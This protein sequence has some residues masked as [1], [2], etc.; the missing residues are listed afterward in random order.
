[1]TGMDAGWYRDPAPANPASPATL[2][3][4][5]GKTWTP[6]TKVAS[7]RVRREWQEEATV[8]RLAQARMAATAAPGVQQAVLGLELETS[9]DFTPDGD[10][11]AGWWSRVGASIVDSLIVSTLGVAFAW[12][13]IGQLMDAFRGYVA[14]AEAASRAGSQPPDLSTFTNAVTGPLVAIAVV[15][16][17]VRFV[18][19]VGFLKGFQAT[20]GKML[21]GLEVRLR[22]RPGPL[23]WGT[24]LIRWVTQNA[25]VAFQLLPV[26]GL[27]GSLYS[28]LDSLWP[29]WDGQ[30]QAIHDKTARTNVVRRR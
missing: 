7:R 20:P 17:A 28:L 2:R 8:A 22:E 14:A 9:R 4:W 19:D 26:V 3:F 18:Y 29:L 10:R 6:Q 13:F 1:M 25:Y 5:D 16:W 21:L 12:R 30:R 15:M 11:L 23:S 27:F 24:V